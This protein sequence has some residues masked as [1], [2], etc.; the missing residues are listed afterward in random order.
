MKGMM[1]HQPLLVSEILEFGAGAYPRAEIVSVRT[2]GDIHRETY[3][4]FRD[5]TVQLAHALQSKLGVELGDRAAT[6]AWNGYRHME[7][8]YA[9]SGIG[10][11]CHTINPRLSAEQFIYIVNHAED[12]VLFLDT[13]FV[14]IIEAVKDH[15]PKDLAYVIMTDRAHMPDNS[16]G[17]LCYEELLEGQPT[18]IEWPQFAEDTACGLCYTS[19]TTGNPKGALYT[20]R[21]TTLHAMMMAVMQSTTF[22]EGRSVLPVVP[23]FHVN[24]WGLPYASLLVGMNMV[25]P[26]PAMDGPSLFK[27]MDQEKVFSAWGVP[28]IWQGLLGEIKKQGRKPEGFGDVV[29]GG[30]AAPRSMIEAFEKMDVCVGHAWGMTEMSPVGTH[31]IMPKWMDDEPFDTRIDYKSKQGRRCFGVELKIVDED[32]NRQPHDGKAVGELFVRGNTIVSGYFRN[33]EATAKAL[34]AEGWFG[35]GDVA[36]IDTDGFMTI[37][38]RAKDLIKSGGEWI[39]SIDLENM[40]MAHPAIAQAA[41]IGVKHP[42]WDERPILVAVLAEGAEAPSLDEVRDHLSSEFAKW[43]LPDDVVWVDAIPLT[44]TGKFSKLNLRKLLAD[45]THP[46][47]RETA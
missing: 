34:D 8:Y 23:L 12:K 44:A 38:D 2:E 17:A 15:L 11:V 14:P 33:E 46:E 47:L 24:A 37:Q 7:L 39:S 42:R 41:A 36:S 1:M 45:Y 22:G 6:L 30:S 29:I 16:F 13:S 21:S 40:A 4:E 9:I 32:G 18:D 25:M 26:G 43:Q 3:V 19:G 28:T 10:A 5:R 31:G 35:T 27:L 20:H